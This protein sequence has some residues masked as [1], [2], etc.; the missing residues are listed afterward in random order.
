MVRIIDLIAV[1]F[2]NRLTNSTRGV[3][4]G[5][6]PASSHNMDL[7]TPFVPAYDPETG[8]ELGEAINVDIVRRHLESLD[9]ADDVIP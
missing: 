3:S 8:V 4:S 2:H 1:E 6:E 7:S 5:D 9:I